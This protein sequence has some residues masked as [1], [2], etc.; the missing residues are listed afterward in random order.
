MGRG[1]RAAT[2]L[3]GAGVSAQGGVPRFRGA[4]GLW[5]N[6]RPEELATPAA[7]AHDPKLVREWHDWRRSA[8]AGAEP[9]AGRRARAAQAGFWLITQNVDGLHERAG[10][11][12]LLHLHGDIWRLRC[13]GCGREEQNRSLPTGH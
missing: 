12:R 7:F 8:V 1:A 4:G 5:H 11:R 10:S 2:V 3:A 13:V 6:F 9:H